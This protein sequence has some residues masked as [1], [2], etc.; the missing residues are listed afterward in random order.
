V[1]GVRASRLVAHRG[2]A[3]RY[4]ENTRIG[5]AAAVARGV[6][7]LEIDVHL[8]S[9]GVPVLLHDP[10]LYRTAG[11]AGLVFGFTAAELGR[12]VVNEQARFG[13]AF[14]GVCIPMLSEVAE[15]LRAWPGATLFV[16]IKE[17]SLARFG[18]SFTLDRVL[19]ALAPVLD[20][21]VVIS[22]SE[23]AVSLARERAGCRIGWVLG[24]WSQSS[25][26]QAERLVPDYLFVDRLFL[27]SPQEALWSGDWRWVVYEVESARQGRALLRLGAHLL[28]TMDIAALMEANSRDSQGGPG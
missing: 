20:S 6:R 25:R 10:D 12:I 17:E 4:P 2:F 27:P 26:R 16:E 3:A 13:G 21:C 15:D 1:T 19:D 28:E 7:Q 5:L 9:D 24:D 22:F 18:D 23:K 14:Q 8:S 11:R